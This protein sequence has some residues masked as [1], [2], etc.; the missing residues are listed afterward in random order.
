M[1]W[2][3]SGTFLCC[4]KRKGLFEYQ[5]ECPENIIPDTDGSLYFTARMTYQ[6]KRRFY[7]GLVRE[8]VRLEAVKLGKVLVLKISDRGLV[9]F[10]FETDGDTYELLQWPCVYIWQGS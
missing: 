6:Q 10:A 1:R 9:L 7:L 3:Y 2:T 4:I 8:L 5:S